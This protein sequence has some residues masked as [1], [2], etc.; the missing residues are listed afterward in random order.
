MPGSSTGGA[1]SATSVCTVSGV[2]RRLVPSATTSGS[3]S[4]GWTIS[5]RD[6]WRAEARFA[7]RPAWRRVRVLVG[8]GTE[9]RDVLGT[10]VDRWES[11][12]PPQLRMWK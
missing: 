3:A 1:T 11:G 6:L 4:C 12:V 8:F 10:P 2:G 9:R 7:A 5:L